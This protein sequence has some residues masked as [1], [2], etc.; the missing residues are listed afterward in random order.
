MVIVKF[1][2]KPRRNSVFQRLVCGDRRL[3]QLN[4]LVRYRMP[5]CL[6]SGFF[7]QMLFLLEQVC[8]KDE[9]LKTAYFL[10]FF[11]FGLLIYL[12]CCCA[13]VYVG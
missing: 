3:I 8:V 1:A 11:F 7:E 2:E 12:G 9:K 10:I 13:P 4:F 5:R 6:W